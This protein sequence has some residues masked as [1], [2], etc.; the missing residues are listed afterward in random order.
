MEV[1]WF[2]QASHTKC[3]QSKEC[4][5]CF[6]REMLLCVYLLMYCDLNI[7]KKGQTQQDPLLHSLLTS[8][9]EGTFFS[10]IRDN[11]HAV[12]INHHFKDVILQPKDV[13]QYIPVDGEE[14][15]KHIDQSLTIQ[16]FIMKPKQFKQVT[17]I[18]LD[19]SEQKYMNQINVILISLIK[20]IRT[21]YYKVTI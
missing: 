21:K 14:L 18:T 19:I 16:Q 4:L 5:I 20:R 6:S 1:T 15:Q 3:F 11:Y 2:W 13:C 7:R 9:I 8:C 17:R 12:A 10:S